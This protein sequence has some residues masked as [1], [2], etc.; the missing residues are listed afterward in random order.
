MGLE[1][2]RGDIDRVVCVSV[3]VSVGVSVCFDR[4]WGVYIVLRRLRS[5]YLLS[6]PPHIFYTILFALSRHPL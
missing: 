5:L 4:G 2:E 6:Q 1:K 3:S